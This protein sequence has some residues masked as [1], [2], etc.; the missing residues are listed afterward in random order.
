[1]FVK[2]IGIESL[3]NSSY[4]VGSED[5]KVCAVV[6]PARDVDMYMDEAAAQGMRIAY[7]LE[8]HVHN[9]FVSG[10]RELAARTG[11]TICAS[12]ACGLL[13][14]HRS[15]NKGDSID[16]GGVQF[17]V[18]AT[19]GHTPEHVSYLATDSAAPRGQGALFSGGAL[20][21]G[22]VA[23]SDMLGKQLAPFLGRWFHRTVQQEFRPLDDRVVVYPT[24]G[25]GSFCSA[26]SSGQ[27]DS[28]TTI[29]RERATN[30]Y[31]QAATEAEFLELALA[32]LPSYPSYYKRM[33]NINRRGPH[34]LGSL[35]ALHPLAPREALVRV[36][37]DGL[38][39][40][41]RSVPAYAHSHIPGAFG[42]PFGGSFGTWVGWLVEP[43][44]PLVL[45]P[46][47]EAIV[48]EAVRQLV[49]IGY[50][51]LDGYLDRGMEG[52]ERAGLPVARLRTASPDQLRQVLDG[53]GDALPLDVRF[54][55]EW[56]EGH[57]P[58]ALHVELGDLP[59][60]L[61]G[62]PRDRAYYALCAA[63]VR[64]AT[65]ASILEREGFEDVTLVEG[66]TEAWKQAGLPLE[67]EG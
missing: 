38:A 54:H 35:P 25:G 12:A 23:R 4:L 32:D 56:R 1:M 34:I 59:E 57:V 27:G 10:S 42:I 60:H 43:G 9:D 29:G 16:L 66:G 37:G 62:L 13:Y 52:W 24:H 31:F 53:N 40:D 46:E 26:G 39:V 14:D 50:D 8:T 67:S 6:D 64:A 44:R 30:P 49:R 51:N 20:L 22:G 36:H 45:V 28:T 19:P 21:V 61:D 41:A 48:E 65:A 17:K 7:A 63:G 58:G 55:H 33:A 2:Q 18:L 47:S 11:A 15:L 3:G 5:A